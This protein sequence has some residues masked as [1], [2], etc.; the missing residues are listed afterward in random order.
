MKEKFGVTKLMQKFIRVFTE[1]P[2]KQSKYCFISCLDDEDN[3][4]QSVTFVFMC[5]NPR[6]GL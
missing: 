1:N 6:L 4:L 3:G 5:L 2:Y